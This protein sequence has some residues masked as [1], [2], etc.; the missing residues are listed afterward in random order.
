[1]SPEEFSI[2]SKDRSDASI[3]VEQIAEAVT[4]GVLRAIDARRTASVNQ[5]GGFDIHIAG[6]RFEFYVGSGVL[7]QA[8]TPGPVGPSVT[9]KQT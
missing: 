1:V 6:G 9:G 8:G 2:M 7:A 5:V 3:S 4:A